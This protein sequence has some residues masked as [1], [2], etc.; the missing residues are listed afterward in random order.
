MHIQEILNNIELPRVYKRNGKDCFFDPYRKRLIEITPEEI[1]RQKVAKYCEVCLNVPADYI[2]LEMPMSKY[3]AGMKGRAD[4]IVHQ[5][6]SDNIMY[7][8]MIVECK[9]P[10]V[11]LTDKVVEQAMGYCDIVGADYFIITNGIDMEIFKYMEDTDEYRKLE[12]ILNYDDM[13]SKNGIPAPESEKPPRFTLQQMQD[14]D[15][16]TDYSKSDV[17]VFGE[18]TPYQ[19][20]PFIIQYTLYARKFMPEKIIIFTRKRFTAYIS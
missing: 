10:K 5:K 18:D 8:L 3:V 2:M 6:K 1:I 7:P 11:S 4:I 17:W 12:N 20:I 15:L 13:I 16:M 14:I 9:Q 19:Y